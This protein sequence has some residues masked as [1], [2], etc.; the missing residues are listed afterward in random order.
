MIQILVNTIGALILI[1]LLVI[2]IANNSDDCKENRIVRLVIELSIVIGLLLFN[3]F[4][5]TY[6]GS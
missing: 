3:L 2:D 4:V 1:V 6:Y 5:G